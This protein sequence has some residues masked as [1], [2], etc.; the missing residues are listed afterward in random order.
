[1]LP[2]KKGRKPKS[3]YENLKLQEMSN[4]FLDIS[5]ISNISNISYISN[6][7]FTGSDGEISYFLNDL[8]LQITPSSSSNKF[9]IYASVQYHTSASSN[10]VDKLSASI[11]RSTS[12]MSGSSWN[13]SL[14][15][16]LANNSNTDV[17]ITSPT[18]QN[19]SLWSISSASTGEHGGTINMQV[20]D[21]ELSAL[22]KY[23]YAIR[24]NT[25]QTNL[26][27]SN[28][29]MSYIQFN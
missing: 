27:F 10:G 17:E 13:S 1:M 28:I 3:Y 6:T 9:V 24:V 12:N 22:T 19:K 29:R 25:E 2:K 26:N 21:T 18:S 5:S 4:N 15:T 23:S 8:N 11:I 14:Y 7:G 16:N 20:F